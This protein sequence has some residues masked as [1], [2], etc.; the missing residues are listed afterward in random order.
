MI[1]GIDNGVSGS[2]TIMSN[3]GTV[4]D[5]FPTPTKK[6]LKPTKKVQW[7]TVVLYDEL[8]YR[9]KKHVEHES[10]VK[11]YM[12]RAFINYKMFNATMSSVMAYIITVLVLE[13]LHIS[14][15]V[16]DSKDWQ[17]HMLPEGILGKKELKEAA[18]C[19][20]NRLFP[21]VRI[22]RADLADSLLIAEYYRRKN[23]GMV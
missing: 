7:I 11:C 3:D 10:S 20:A 15:E 6:T 17:K 8:Y 4:L 2:I 5:Y 21:S 18:K 9:L 14:Y 22:K 19:V 1:I 23:M 16:V 12:E 13:Q